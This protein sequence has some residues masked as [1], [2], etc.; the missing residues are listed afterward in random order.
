[1]DAKQGMVRADVAID[2]ERST[3]RVSSVA[4]RE[5]GR[6][7]KGV[8][9]RLVDKRKWRGTLQIGVKDGFCTLTSEERVVE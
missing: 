8:W 3:E 9:A 2:V 5:V 6:D 7:I 4:E 1:M